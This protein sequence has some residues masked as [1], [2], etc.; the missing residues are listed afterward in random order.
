MPETQKFLT[1]DLGAES[2]RSVLGTISG[3][4]L[5]LDEVHRF[6]NEPQWILGRY[7]WDT[8]RLFAEIKAGLAKCV[9]AHGGQLDGIGVDTWGVDFALLDKNDELLGQPYHYRDHRTDGVMER[10]FAIVPRGE[11]Y[12]TTGIQ[13]MQL[14]TLFQLMAMRLADSPLL[15]S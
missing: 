13:F 3:G 15:N 2:G 12:R 5:T 1:F 8:L 6:P 11:I 7:H 14:N 9:R 10:T 4:K